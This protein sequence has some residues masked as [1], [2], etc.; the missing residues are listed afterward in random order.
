[1]DLNDVMWRAHHDVEIIASQHE[2][3]KGERTDPLK[4]GFLGLDSSYHL[5][6]AT[7]GTKRGLFE[8]LVYICIN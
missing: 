1:M 5:V 8:V 7:V 3:A 6:R 2:M 4:V